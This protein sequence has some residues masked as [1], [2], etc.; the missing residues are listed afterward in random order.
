MRI[1]IGNKLKLGF[2]LVLCLMVISS[3]LSF[4]QLNKIATIENRVVELR[5]PT[6]VNGRDLLNGINQSLADLRGYMILGAEPDVGD[7]FKNNREQAWESIDKAV[8]E[9]DRFAHNWTVPENI[10]QLAT[11]KA[12]I[13]E[14][15]VA[16]QKVED[17][18]HSHKN[19]PAF[20][21]LI[22]HAA[23]MAAQTIAAITE[24]INIEEQLDATPQRKALLKNL[25]DSR[26]SFALGL[27]NI[28]AYLLS[29]DDKF[30]QTFERNWQANTEALAK[31]EASAWLFSSEQLPLWNNYIKHR[32]TFSNY[33]R[34]MFELRASKSWNLANSLLAS[35]AAPRAAII[36][37]ILETMRASQDQLVKE[38]V[39]MLAVTNTLSVREQTIATVIA[40]IVSLLI[41]IYIS[42]Q[43]TMAAQQILARTKDI[44]QGDLSGKPLI[45]NSDDELSEI[46]HVLNDMSQ[47]LNTMLKSVEAAANEVSSA[48]LQ[49]TSGSQKTSSAMYDQNQ[50]AHTVSSAME[51]MSASTKDVAHASV[52]AST[53]ANTTKSLALTGKEA[54]NKTI[55]DIQ[56]VSEIMVN[57]SLS[58]KQLGERGD[59]IGS[60]VAVINSI[61]EQTNLLALNAAIE[62]ARAGEYGRGFS[63][64]ADEVRNLAQ[65]TV[66]A[67]EEIKQSISAMQHQTTIV[68]QQMDGSTQHVLQGLELARNAGVQLEHI[69]EQA[70]QVADSI[71]SIASVGEQQAC[72]SEDV[73]HN[74]NNM[75]TVINQTLEVTVHAAGTAKQLE[76]KAQAL[77]QLTRKFKLG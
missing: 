53:G 25:A 4:I 35:E 70:Q 74:I 37:K 31:L 60:I 42:R 47:S 17:I 41:A 43:I 62:A 52:N 75:A 33:P 9:L 38:D 1:S 3:T 54:V 64:V 39:A 29:G 28:R 63:V 6:I 76:A 61:A 18:A 13:E 27:A 40:I 5:F 26:G 73:A 48:A 72:V 51:E 20:D 36:K 21:M 59:E 2:G 34:Q 8:S 19:I 14:F 46:A 30:R 45:M 65:R 32:M 66:G 49:I 22:T 23:P 16:Q 10:K 24:L 7:K 67:T 15:R 57:S 12:T 56:R 55:I 77:N 71:N 11:L 58:V 69:V 68:I 44:A 50:Q